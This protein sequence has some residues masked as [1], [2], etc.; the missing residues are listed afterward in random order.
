MYTYHIIS[1]HIIYYAKYVVTVNHMLHLMHL[2]KSNPNYQSTLKWIFSNMFQAAWAN[3]DTGYSL[4]HNLT[5]LTLQWTLPRI[6]NID[7][8]GCKYMRIQHKSVCN[9]AAL[10]YQILLT[11]YYIIHRSCHN[12]IK[13]NIVFASFSAHR[14]AGKLSRPRLLRHRL[15]SNSW[16]SNSPRTDARTSQVSSWFVGENKGKSCTL[17]QIVHNWMLL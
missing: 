14:I 13:H 4:W 16:R 3:T 12:I 1:Y 6:W 8:F 2:I 7:N 10:S 5:D 9:T 17:W 15:T 11:L